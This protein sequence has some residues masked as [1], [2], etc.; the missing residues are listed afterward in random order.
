MDGTARYDGIDISQ[1]R[2]HPISLDI[3]S[4]PLDLLLYLVQKDKVEIWEI[5]IAR[6]TEQYLEYIRSLDALNVEIAGEFLVMAATLIRIKSQM[7]LPRPDLGE[8]EIETLPMTREELIRRLIEFR[9]YKEAAATL[10][11]M[12]ESRLHCLP[13]GWVPRLPKDHLYPLREARVLDLTAYL[14]EVL[15]RSETGPPTHD[16]ELEE[17][18]LEDQI[19]LLMEKL[20]ES[21]Q[22]RCFID[23]L[24]RPWWR[25]EWIMTFLAMLELMRQGKL[26]ALQEK[27]FGEL[28]LTPTVRSEEEAAEP[29]GVQEVVASAE[30]LA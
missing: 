15:N 30:D 21:D 20:H 19:E 8:D 29:D 13:R 12:E 5:S 3:F 4:G 27:P 9:R 6:I 10:K 2:G 25:L 7:L 24:E 28:W 14:S 22:P 23:L 16:V 26:A 1:F 18:R 17:I 11:R